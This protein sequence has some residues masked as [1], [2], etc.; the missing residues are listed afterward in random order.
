MKCIRTGAKPP[1][2]SIEQPGPEWQISSIDANGTRCSLNFIVNFIPYF[3]SMNT[4]KLI[5]KCLSEMITTYLPLVAP[6]SDLALNSL[7]LGFQL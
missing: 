5:K 2:C 6:K 7:R 4:V 1:Y 3:Q